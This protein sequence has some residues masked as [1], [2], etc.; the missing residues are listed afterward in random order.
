MLITGMDG[1]CPV[2]EAF[3]VQFYPTMVL[4][5]RQGRIIWREQGATDVTLAR[6]DRFILK[7]LHRS[8][9]S[10]ETMQARAS[11]PRDDAISR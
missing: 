11:A 8:G 7:N 6:M 9:N 1:T 4:V 5:D 2:Q 3:Q 10:G